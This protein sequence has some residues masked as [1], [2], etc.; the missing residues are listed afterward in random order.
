MNSTEIREQL[1]RFKKQVA[2]YATSG[3]LIPEAATM[4]TQVITAIMLGEIAYQLAFMNEQECR[5]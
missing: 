1:E 2:V 5:R 3:G 4:A